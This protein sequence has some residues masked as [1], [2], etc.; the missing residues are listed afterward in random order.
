MQRAPKVSKESTHN[1]PCLIDKWRILST[2]MGRFVNNSLHTRSAGTFLL[3]RYLEMRT[4]DQQRFLKSLQNSRKVTI[5]DRSHRLCSGQ[6]V[7]FQQWLAMQIHYKSD[8]VGMGT[9]N[10]CMFAI[11]KISKR[12]NAFRKI[13]FTQFFFIAV[14]PTP[15]GTTL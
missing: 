12:H 3:H 7:R 13:Q 2:S 11:N 4:D 15:N 10:A 6:F 14:V 1:G 8:Q 5:S 9:D